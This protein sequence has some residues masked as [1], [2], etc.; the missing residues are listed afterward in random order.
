MRIGDRVVIADDIY[1][2]AYISTYMGGAP[3]IA[4]RGEIG[5][6]IRER[7]KTSV[8]LKMEVPSLSS[9]VCHVERHEIIG[10]KRWNLQCSPNERIKE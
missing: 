3:K 10:I 7:T 4:S 8:D 9:E 2:S 5:V 1:G 6:I